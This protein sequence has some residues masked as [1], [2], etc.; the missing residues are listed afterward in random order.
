MPTDCLALAAVAGAMILEPRASAGTS[1]MI[2]LAPH[3]TAVAELCYYNHIAG[4]SQFG[5][6]QME[7]D[8]VP[9]IVT[10]DWTEGTEE[11][12]TIE[13][14]VGYF[15]Y[16]ADAQMIDL[17]DGQVIQA[18]IMTCDETVKEQAMETEVEQMYAFE[19]ALKDDNER[20]RAKL[21]EKEDTDEQERPTP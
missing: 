10:V 20:L 2:V 8:G 6:H 17:P 19:V 15:V 21:A 4:A 1:D 16:P 18:L 7:I 11:R 5:V 3:A 13:V 9:V 12:I 14:P